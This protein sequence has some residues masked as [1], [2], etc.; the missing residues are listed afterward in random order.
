MA[1]T[2][3]PVSKYLNLYSMYIFSRMLTY[4]SGMPG[5]G[6]VNRTSVFKC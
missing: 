1:L 3:K 6:T 5:T 2:R 4:Y